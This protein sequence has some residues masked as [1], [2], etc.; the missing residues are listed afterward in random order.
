MVNFSAPGVYLVEGRVSEEFV[1]CAAF[2]V[3]E[4]CL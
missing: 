3:W 1:L 4:I 2:C